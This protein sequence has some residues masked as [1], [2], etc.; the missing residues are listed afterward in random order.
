M[1]FHAF[2]EA[3]IACCAL[4]GI[5]EYELY[6][7][8][9]ESTS[10]GAFQKEINQ[11]TG[12]VEGGVCFRCIV[13]GKMGYASTEELSE[14]QAAAIVEKA[15][16][17]ATA[18]ETEDSV[19]LGEGGQ[20]YE[21]V[22]RANYEL[23][24]TEALIEAVL[25]TQ[26]K[27]YETD[28]AVVDGTMTQGFAERNQLAIYNSKGLDLSYANQATGLV[29]SAVIS[30]DG[31]KVDDFAFKLA[32]LDTIDQAA[33]ADKVTKGARAKLGGEIAPTGTY[34]VVF[35]PRAM[36]D[37]LQTFS[38]IFSSETAQK[39]LS[40]LA[41]KEGQ[42]IASEIVTIVDDPFHKDNPMPIH[43]DAE[44]SPTC[45]KEVVE[46]GD[47]NTLLYNLKTA[48][49]AGKQTTGNAA[50]SGYNAAVA[51]RPFTMYLAGGNISEEELLQKAG[52][53]VYINALEGLHA[54]ANAVSGDFSLQS[55][56]F[57]I[58]N[59]QKTTHVKGFTVAGNFYELLKNITAMADNVELPMALGMTAFG[60]PSV[61]VQGLSIAGK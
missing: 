7:Q 25:D 31:E 20:T 37:L 30:V 60:A 53:G 43:F 3:V 50:K 45:S 52:N 46:G 12:S 11:F 14:E 5:T 61:L 10:V 9:A 48:N 15:A 23:P 26:A 34:P 6:Y 39:G 8:S 13:D 47:L 17:N 18:L 44:G 24:S 36:S 22:E 4:R 35:N 49:I 29:V 16:D 1:E 58:E 51:V 57:M 19:F 33:L 21:P 38:G 55:A 59:G 28:S 42:I 27:L 54:G 2:K 40:Q 41:D 56:G 32:K